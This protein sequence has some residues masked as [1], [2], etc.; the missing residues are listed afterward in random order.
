MTKPALRV[1][2]REHDVV[3]ALRAGERFAVDDK[4]LRI[5]ALRLHRRRHQA[6]DRIGDV[7]RLVE[8]VGGIKARRAARARVDQFVEDEEQAER[9]DRS[10]VEIVVAIF[11]I[12]EVKAGR[13]ARRG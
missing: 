6:L 5:G 9:V 3:R 2:W 8:H 1:R 7:V 12:V 4:R 13:A 11:R 10:G